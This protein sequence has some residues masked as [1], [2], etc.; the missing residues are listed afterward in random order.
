MK[1]IDFDSFQVAEDTPVRTLRGFTKSEN[2]AS[3][4][5]IQK[6]L[7]ERR[8]KIQKVAAKRIEEA[9]K[10]V[11]DG[12]ITEEDYKEYADTIKKGMHTSVRLI[13]SYI[14]MGISNANIVRAAS[15]LNLDEQEDLA[16]Q[17]IRLVIPDFDREKE[18]ERLTEGE[19]LDIQNKLQKFTMM[20]QEEKE[21]LGFLSDSPAPN[22]G[23]GLA[24]NAGSSDSTPK[25]TATE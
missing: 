14:D 12:L 22:T 4:L 16:F 19:A 3:R 20:T 10:D 9:K 11:E 25:E 23:N 24:K 21:E 6:A 1:W 18:Y 15:N 2:K 5:M 8:A 17:T 13:S 7:S